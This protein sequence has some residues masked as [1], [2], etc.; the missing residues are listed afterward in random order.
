MIETSVVSGVSDPNDSQNSASPVF[1]YGA[2]PTSARF[3]YSTSTAA[4]THLTIIAPA[5]V[6]PAFD[7]KNI[8]NKARNAAR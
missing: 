4:A 3:T 7:F 8:F 2:S 5:Q 1:G 6:A